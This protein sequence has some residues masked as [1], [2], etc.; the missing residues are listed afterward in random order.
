MS[1]VRWSLANSQPHAALWWKECLG[2]V[3]SC[4][5]GWVTSLLWLWTSHWP[6]R[7]N[8]IPRAANFWGYSTIQIKT[9]C[10][11]WQKL[12]S[13]GSDCLLELEPGLFSALSF[14]ICKTWTRISL[15]QTHSA[16]GYLEITVVSAADH[17]SHNMN[18]NLAFSWAPKSLWMVTPAR[19]LKDACSLEGKLW[20]T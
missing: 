5:L 18:C 12:P 14:L 19:K 7:N 8:L 10:E 1:L 3:L 4:K 16:E 6:H 13:P 17:A 2:Q 15:F 20:Q 9:T 11:T